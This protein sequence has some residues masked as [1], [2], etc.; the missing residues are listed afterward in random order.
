VRFLSQREEE[1]WQKRNSDQKEFETWLN[2][3]TADELRS[4]YH[5]IYIS[6]P[7]KRHDLWR[8]I[9]E[10]THCR[11][12][13]P[14]LNTMSDAQFQYWVNSAKRSDLEYV[15]HR[16][17]I[18]GKRMDILQAWLRAIPN[19]FYGPAPMGP[20][21]TII[22]Y[23]TLYPVL[24]GFG[25]AGRII[26]G[27]VLFGGGM[28]VSGPTW[29]RFGQENWSAVSDSVMNGAPVSH[30]LWVEGLHEIPWLIPSYLLFR[31]A[32]LWWSKKTKW[33]QKPKDDRPGR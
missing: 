27:G 30:D 21:D 33:E 4:A 13:P 3:A 25:L 11:N 18:D 28:M 23:L 10:K 8:K 9:V 5:H 15:E 26:W 7:Q 19:P 29:F 14:D 32:Y 24:R 20:I 6:D 31:G 22:K 1:R 12:I 17:H 2:A 16:V